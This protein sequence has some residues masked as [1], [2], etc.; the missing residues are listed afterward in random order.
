[1]HKYLGFSFVPGEDVP[2]RG[3]RRLLP[4]QIATWRQGKLTRVPFLPKPPTETKP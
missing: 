2:V 4:G 1:M 3:V